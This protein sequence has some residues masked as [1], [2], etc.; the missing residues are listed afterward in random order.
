M[1][2]DE[3]IIANGITVEILAKLIRKHEMNAGK[4]RKYY[5]YYIGKHDILNHTKDTR[6]AANNRVVCNHAKYI[7]DI[8][9]AYLVGNPVKYEVSKGYDIEK[10]KDAYL[11]QNIEHIDGEL[12]KNVGIYGRAYELVY[13]TPASEPRSAFIEPT[14][15]FV[16][17]NDD[18]THFPLFGVYYYRTFNLDGAVSGCVCNVYTENE[19]FT[20]EN[21]TDAWE[22]MRLTYQAGHYF[23]DVPLIEYRN[24]EERQGDC[25]QL[26][27]LIDAYNKLQS[28]RVNDK[29]DFV[30]S[31]LF[32]KD[33]LLD[34][35]DVR[36]LKRERILMGDKD[37]D[38]KYLNKIMAESDIKTLRDDLKSDIHRF[39]TVPDLTDEKFAGMQSGIA[40]RYKLLGFGQ[41]TKNKEEMTSAGL[42]KR[43]KL[44]NH[45]LSILGGMKNVP[46]H[47]VDVIFTYNLPVNNLENA[48]M[49]NYLGDD[50][51]LETKLSQLDFISDPKEE[52]ALVRAE[53]AAEYEERIKR[54]EGIAGGGGYGRDFNKY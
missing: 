45:Y 25:E 33:L 15:A 28:E 7:V 39:S 3:R 8:A 13:A 11:E 14:K 40:I 49:L 4:F 1:I 21:D 43:F 9:R 38:A 34:S 47:R 54:V 12:V 36:K 41:T 31:F 24:N 18:C 37:S 23:G 32:L 27:P 10:I 19:I 16:V 6:G 20:Y 5:D 48:Q 46:L 17:Y 50:V 26:I 22:G 53:R 51:S 44:Y 52:A 2:I 29:E 30:N 35:E 42:K